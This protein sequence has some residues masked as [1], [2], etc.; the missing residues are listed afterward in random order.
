M[1]IDYKLIGSRISQKRKE[2]KITQKQLSELIGISNTHI[3][4]I[5]SG[6]KTPSLETLLKICNVLGITIDYLLHGIIHTNIDD[7]IKE[8]TKLCSIQ[9]KKRISKII[10]VFIEEEQHE[11][12]L[13]ENYK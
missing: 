12:E 7:E 6:E 4:S 13:K 5:E 9:N 10:D 8:K 1:N 3:C 2:L 11:K